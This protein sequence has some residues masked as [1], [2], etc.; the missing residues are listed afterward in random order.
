MPRKNSRAILYIE[1]KL[2][3]GRSNTSRDYPIVCLHAD[4]NSKPFKRRADF[5]RHYKHRHAP[6]SR[7][8]AYFCDYGR[9]TRRREPFHRRDHFR[10]HLRDFHKE[11][12]EKRGGVIKE[13]WLE[14]RYV[15]ETW[16]RCPR[17]L[18]RIY[19][20]GHGYDCP[21]CKTSCQ[22]KRKEA[23]LRD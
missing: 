21:S 15:P 9:C 7:K 1:P 5:D 8:E 12:I 19:I 4:C 22:P 16:W 6:D 13:E 3:T 20:E 10:D 14:G 18:K 23:R 11:D 17:C 2:T